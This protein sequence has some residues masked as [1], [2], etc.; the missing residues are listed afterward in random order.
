MT[1]FKKIKEEFD[2][3][4]PETRKIIQNNLHKADKFLDNPLIAGIINNVS[5]YNVEELKK[6]LH[7]IGKNETDG[8]FAVIQKD[9]PDQKSQNAVDIDLKKKAKNEP[10][11]KLYE[12]TDNHNKPDHNNVPPP[13]IPPKH[14]SGKVDGIIGPREI[15]LLV[16][17]AGMIGWLFYQ[18][19]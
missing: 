18:S 14:T 7:K 6:N 8:L 10:P 5:G 19:Y 3:L 1:D 4:P 15:I 12:E 2:K 17:I 11:Q 16:G 9:N 13:P